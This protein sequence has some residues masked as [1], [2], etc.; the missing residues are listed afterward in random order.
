MSTIHE[1]TTGSKIYYASLGEIEGTATAMAGG[2]L[3]RAE[4]STNLRAET[5]MVDHGNPDL[6]L[7]GLCA[8]AD[9]QRELDYD[10]AQ[11]ERGVQQKRCGL[12]WN[13]PALAHPYEGREGELVLI[14]RACYEE[15]SYREMYA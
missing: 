3:F 12:C 2:Y 5:R 7:Y 9:Y 15:L 10:K 8:L 6:I 1:A 11:H 13:G 4:A 14:C